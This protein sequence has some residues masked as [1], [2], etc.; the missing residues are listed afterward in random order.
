MS[1]NHITKWAQGI[2]GAEQEMLLEEY[3]SIGY[4][5][6]LLHYIMN[7][8]STEEDMPNLRDLLSSLRD[9]FLLDESQERLTRLLRQSNGF[10]IIK[11]CY[12]MGDEQVSRLSDVLL[13]MAESS[14]EAF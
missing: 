13:S 5:N 9:L 14:Q 8:Y 1:I 10:Q 4:G 12:S 2:D 11:G 6:R 3:M 7:I